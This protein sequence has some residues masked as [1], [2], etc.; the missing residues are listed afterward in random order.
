MMTLYYRLA[1]ARS[2]LVFQLLNCIEPLS[3]DVET[4][5]L[6]NAGRATKEEIHKSL[7]ASH[8]TRGGA[9]WPAGLDSNLATTDWPPYSVRAA[10]RTSTL[11]NIRGSISRQPSKCC[12]PI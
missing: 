12:M 8:C 4:F 1:Q 10:L 9:A 3:L 5:L 11:G 6:Y 7:L 2:K